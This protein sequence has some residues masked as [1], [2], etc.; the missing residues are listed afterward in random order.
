ML[1]VYN[2]TTQTLAVNSALEFSS[3]AIKTNCSSSIQSN[4]TTITLNKPG[5]YIV[6][7]NGIAQ[8]TD[9]GVVQ[10]QLEKDGT[11]VPYALAAESGVAGDTVNLSFKTLIPVR[12]SCPAMDN[13]VNLTFI[14]NG[15]AASY[16]LTNVVVTRVAY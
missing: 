4:S 9:P 16:T 5:F 7:F 1:Q 11:L 2:T 8:A 6:E 13:T 3:T 14:N 15:V 10:V 12:C